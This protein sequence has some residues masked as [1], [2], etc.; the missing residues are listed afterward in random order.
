[1]VGFELIVP[2][3]LLSFVIGEIF[4]PNTDA[5]GRYLNHFFVID[6]IKRIF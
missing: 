4:L 6:I 5:L 2:R 1:M 3:G